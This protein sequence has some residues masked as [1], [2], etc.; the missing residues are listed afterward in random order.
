MTIDQGDSHRQRSFGSVGLAAIVFVVITFFVLT[1]PDY[2]A[3]LVPAT[4]LRIPLEIPLAGLLLLLLPRRTALALAAL[5]TLLIAILLFLKLADLGVETA[6][7][8]PFNP[9]LD[10]KMLA[11]GWNVLSGAVGTLKAAFVTGAAIFGYIAILYLFWRTQKHMAG[12]GR[13]EAH[14]TALAFVAILALGV[15]LIMLSQVVPVRSFADLRTPSYVS[16]R[17]QLVLRSVADMR[18]FENALS[19]QEALPPTDQLFQAIKGRDVVVIF[20]ESYGR[21]AIEDPR[22]KPVLAPR[23][24]AIERELDSAGF[25]SASGWSLSPTM[26]GLS[27]LAHGTLLSGLWINNQAR[28]DRLMISDRDS[29]NRLFHEAG[30]RTAAVMPA[31]TANWPESSYF[32]YD[33]IFTAAD[34]GYKGKPFN[35]VTMPDQYTLAAFDRLVRHGDVTD[36]RPVMTEMTLVSSHAPWTPVPRLID[37]ASVGD[38]RVFDDQ[39]TSGETPAKVWSDPD[40]I[41]RHYIATIDYSMQT[42]GDYISRYGDNAVFIIL[43]DHQPAPLVTGDNASR[44]VPVHVIT[45]DAPLVDSFEKNGFTAGMV[46]ASSAADIPMDAMRQLLIRLFSAS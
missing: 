8:R 40:D 44:D 30:W 37:W 23:L 12:A 4:F 24:S 35:W 13:V 26:G 20:V 7:R 38:G 28:Y 3:A 39:A 21:S 31:I 11:D 36:N 18:R 16:A 43:G 2:P 27:W 17:I 29:L 33:D 34:L 25:S 1:L 41:R 10:L 15:V 6:F 42:I 5:F 32:G 22:Y 9:Y 46:P 14:V 19:R 45:R